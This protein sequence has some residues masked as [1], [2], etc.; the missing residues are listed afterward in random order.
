LEWVVHKKGIYIRHQLNSTEKRI[1]G[2]KLPV[3]GFNPEKQ[4]V[5]QFHGCYWHSHDCALNRGKEFNEKDETNP[6][7]NCWNK[8]EPTQ[9]TLRER[10]P[11]HRDV[12]MG[13]A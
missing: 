1:G 7:W 4:T 6:W 5:Y 13:L 3:D 9:N 10:I 11:G 2:R 8:P 12:G